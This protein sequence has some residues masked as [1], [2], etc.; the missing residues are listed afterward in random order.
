MVY[1]GDSTDAAVAPHKALGAGHGEMTV[2]IPPR[3][4]GA[5]NYQLYLS[6]DS[7]MDPMGPAIDVPAIVGEFRLDDGATRL[8]NRRA[9]FL[10]RSEERRV[11]KECRSRW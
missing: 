2:E 9:G 6:F 1:E 5:G 11:G 10:S 7:D 3:V 4:L 8:G